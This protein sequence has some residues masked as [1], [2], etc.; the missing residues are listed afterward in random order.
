MTQVLTPIPGLASFEQSVRACQEAGQAVV[1]RLRIRLGPQP[2]RCV[3]TAL[4][5]ADTTF[6]LAGS[7]LA[8]G[9]TERFRFTRDHFRATDGRTRRQLRQL[10][11]ETGDPDLIGLI[12]QWEEADQG[13]HRF[14]QE[15]ESL[16]GDLV[17]AEPAS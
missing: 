11:E 14:L 4:G 8:A 7:H 5:D 13:R 9:R 6:H 3:E 2:A 12:D 16:W 15:A 1:R 10:A 17:A